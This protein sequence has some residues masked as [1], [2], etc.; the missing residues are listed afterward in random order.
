M[1]GASRDLNLPKMVHKRIL[2]RGRPL[3]NGS[4]EIGS[5][6]AT[7][8]P[9]KQLGSKRLQL[10]KGGGATPFLLRD[11]EDGDVNSIPTA[12]TNHPSDWSGLNE[13]ARGKKG[14]EKANDPVGARHGDTEEPSR[15]LGRRREAH[16]H[17]ACFNHWLQERPLP[18]ILPRW[19]CLHIHND[20][21]PGLKR[22][23]VTE[24]RL[25]ERQVENPRKI[26]ERQGAY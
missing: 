11:L 2:A 10:N 3:R 6:P 26:F 24:E 13:N 21:I 22:K 25:E 15:G 14:T 19:N 18:M 8:Q 7:D 20:V 5:V 23:G 4:T 9:L 12:P 16:F 17:A 1:Y